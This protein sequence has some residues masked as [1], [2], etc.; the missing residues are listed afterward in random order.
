MSLPC[1]NLYQSFRD[2]IMS[3]LR[4]YA[5]GE[6]GFSTAAEWQIVYRAVRTEDVIVHSSTATCGRNRAPKNA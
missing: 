1:T 4:L 6:T 5:V 3:L 2:H